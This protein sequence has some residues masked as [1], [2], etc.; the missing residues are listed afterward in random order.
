MGRA[1]DGFFPIDEMLIDAVIDWSYR[2]IVGGEDPMTGAK[3]ASELAD[4]LAGSIC[5]AGIGGPEALR[6]WSQTIVP[7][8]RA[9]GD[10]MNLAYVP[11]APTAAALTFDLA[12]SSAQIMGA[13][14]ECGAGAIAAENQALRWL[15]DLAG[16]P[17]SAGGVFVQGG[18]IGN[19]SAL[20]AAREHARSTRRDAA[21]ARWRI[22]AG[23][24]AHSSIT[25]AAR[26]MDVDVLWIEG[27]E[28]GRI[29]GAAL[30]AT[31]AD[32]GDPASVFA[33]VANVGAT[34]A[35]IIDRLDSVADVC[36]AHALWLHVDGAY[37]LA[38]LVA[39]SMHARL[40][41][42]DRVDSFVVD[43]HKWLFAP[44]D[45]CALVYRDAARARVAH[46]QHAGYL[47]QIDRD[48]WN[49]SDHAIQLSRRA[50][51]LP[52]LVLAR[53]LR[54]RPL[55][56]GDRA[57]A[58]HRPRRGRRHPDERPPRAGDGTRPVDPAVPAH[59]LDRGADAGLERR[60]RPARHGV[61]RAHPLA[62]RAGLPVVLREPPHRPRSRA[63]RPRHAR[64]SAG[65]HDTHTHTHPGRGRS[66][67]HTDGRSPGS[68]IGASHQVDGIGNLAVVPRS[69][70][71]ADVRVEQSAER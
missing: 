52:P 67:A 43:P 19:L 24:A 3:P 57:R 40:T 30:A 35:G 6:R 70:S 8:T 23:R 12:V 51:G 4:A 50:R 48:E 7:A 33:V 5:P 69:N 22:A 31:L 68:F 2:R 16:W 10:P 58:G 32:D 45:C 17:D 13:L 38:A 18:T 54:H 27:D 59:R 1:T 65:R 9:M 56:R 26:V 21:P 62:R 15:T 53:H 39:P 46:S 71:S 60:A 37:G 66:G 41:G 64:L 42:I 25:A 61:D 63:A 28:A 44:Y 11:A 34:N 14:W 29:D 49:P 36:E 20:A 47:E 55:R